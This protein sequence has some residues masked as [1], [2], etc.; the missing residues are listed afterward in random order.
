MDHLCRYTF[1]HFLD[2]QYTVSIFV[3]LFE[4]FP[5]V[6]DLLFGKLWGN[7]R[8]DDFLE[9]CVTGEIFQWGEIEG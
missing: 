3:K 1:P 9:S 4:E 5:Q 8:E 6:S 7:K 2:G